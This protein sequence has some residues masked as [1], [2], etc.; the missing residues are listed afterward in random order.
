M[1]KIE[2]NHEVTKMLK[3]LVFAIAVGTMALLTT[4][5]AQCEDIKEGKYGIVNSESGKYLDADSFD[6]KKNGCKVQLWGDSD[7]GHTHRQWKIAKF[8]DNAY[9]ITSL[10][11]DK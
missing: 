4:S 3:K 11:V 5:R 10:A 2:F 6:L 1:R 8:G 9:T 7:E